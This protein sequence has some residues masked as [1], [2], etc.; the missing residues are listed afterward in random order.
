MLSWSSPRSEDEP[1]HP[2]H[3]IKVTGMRLGP[4]ARIALGTEPDDP[5]LA[6]SAE[7]EALRE[8]GQNES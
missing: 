3:T 6:P 1:D 5:E 7:P 8:T 4:S 2:D